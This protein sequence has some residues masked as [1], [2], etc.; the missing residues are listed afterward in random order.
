MNYLLPERLDALA[1]EYVLGTLAGPARRRFEAVL[2]HTP[3]AAAVVN[4]WRQRL[5]V[6]N[7]GI[8]PL[9]PPPSNWRAIEQR[10]FPAT[11]RSR[12]PR[13]LTGLGS[14]LGG[15]LAG[16]VLCIGVLR[17]E[18]QLAGLEPRVE[19]LP[20]SYVGLLLDRRDQP[21]LLASSRRQG[22]VLTLKMLRPLAVPEGQVAQLWAL[23]QDGGAPWPIGTLPA[24]GSAQ[25]T[26]PADSEALFAK[27]PRLGVSLEAQP[28]RAGDAPAG[29]FVLTG[30]CVKMW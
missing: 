19:A 7:L 29:E 11:A 26:L 9:D 1:R 23:P 12:W 10:L 21:T 20:A 28:A 5:A 2:R 14:S 22:R 3:E 8:E 4:Q 15:A 27:V 17:N 25:L 30:H 24:S 18:P 16:V 13:W 6:L